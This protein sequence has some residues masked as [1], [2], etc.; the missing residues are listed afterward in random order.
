[1]RSARMT[2]LLAE[3]ETW[4]EWFRM[5][6]VAPSESAAMEMWR[7]APDAACFTP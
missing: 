4:F 3:V 5:L 1:M 6:S 7:A 2:V